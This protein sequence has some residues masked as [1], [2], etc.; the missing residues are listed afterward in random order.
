VTLCDL[1]HWKRHGWESPDAPV[2]HVKNGVRYRR[3]E[4]TCD[5]PGC[6]A[7]ISKRLS[8]VKAHNFCSRSHATKY[9]AQQRIK[10]G[11]FML[12]RSRVAKS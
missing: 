6:G 12:R 4:G 11:T 2:E 1:C 9:L 10:D 5:L 7:F 3:W 8:E